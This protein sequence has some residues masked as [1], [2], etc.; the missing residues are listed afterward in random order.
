VCEC[1]EHWVQSLGEMVAHTTSTNLDG[2]LAL[3][4]GLNRGWLF[5]AQPYE[6]RHVATSEPEFPS[7]PS[8]PC[9]DAHRRVTYR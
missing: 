9:P 4:L 3:K 5:G 2:R 6:S 7:L 1:A 8:F